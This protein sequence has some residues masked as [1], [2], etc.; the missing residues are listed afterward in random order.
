MLTIAKIPQWSDAAE[1]GLGETLGKFRDELADQV[2][3]GIAELWRL[4]RRTY[5]LTRLDKW[6]HGSELVVCC[7]KGEGLHEIAPVIIE[8]AKKQG[9]DSIRFHTTRPGL[10]RL[11]S[12]YGFRESERVYTLDLKP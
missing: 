2:N 4:G 9:I 7:L 5:L 3:R 1:L 10:S 6:A 11:V 12:R 8:R